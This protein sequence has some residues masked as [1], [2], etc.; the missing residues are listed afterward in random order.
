MKI[1]QARKKSFCIFEVGDECLECFLFSS[2]IEPIHPLLVIK[3]IGLRLLNKRRPHVFSNF[4]FDLIQL[5]YKSLQEL[6]SPVD[7]LFIGAI[8]VQEDRCG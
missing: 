7:L 2:C 5:F 3:L 8:N 6:A 1:P 4:P